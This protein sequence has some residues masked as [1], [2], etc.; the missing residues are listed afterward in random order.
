MKARVQSHINR[1]NPKP[2]GGQNPLP[3]P[4][5]SPCIHAYLPTLNIPCLHMILFSTLYLYCRLT[6]ISLN[7]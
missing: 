3:T 4:L 1:Q 2:R 5:T 6:F 7:M